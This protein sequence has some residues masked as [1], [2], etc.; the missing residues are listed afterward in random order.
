MQR[1]MSRNQ[2]KSSR[3]R[4]LNRLSRMKRKTK[5]NPKKINLRNKTKINL[6]NK[7]KTNPK[8]KTKIFLK[9]KTWN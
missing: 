8:S 4:S 5:R 6:K 1:M 2:M 7:M 9:M 3:M